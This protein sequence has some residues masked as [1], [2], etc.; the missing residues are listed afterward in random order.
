MIIELQD[1][2]KS[3]GSHRVLDRVCARI[4][5]AHVLAVL[6]P[7]GCGKSTLL[8]LIAGLDRPDSGRIVIDGQPLP[9]DESGLHAWRKRIGV[10][11]QSFNL[12]PHLN[13][14]D[15]LL[16]PLTQVHR[17][18]EADANSQALTMLERFQLAEHA[19]KRPSMLSG[20]QRQRVAI[21]RALACR[22]AFLLF[23]EP[24]SALDPEM[25]AEVLD[26]ILQL[27]TSATPL[28]L[29]THELGF[30]QEAADWVLFLEHGK[31]DASQAATEFFQSPATAAATRFLSRL[32]RF[33]G[34]GISGPSEPAP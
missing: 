21:A 18:S 11:F 17:L 26:V 19:H 20:G 33:D 14:M 13:A 22:P 27:R 6:G 4:S 5:F 16:L 24:T 9:A 1:V 3:F 25:T 7:S 15:N 12:F 34:C 31:I 32:L 2:T 28:L 29:V 30:A 8:R 23:D 10:V